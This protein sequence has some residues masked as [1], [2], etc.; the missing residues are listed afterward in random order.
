M[1]SYPSRAPIT[2]AATGLRTTVAVAGLIEAGDPGLP[3]PLSGRSAR[4]GTVIGA[5]GE[6]VIVGQVILA[7]DA[8]I[9]GWL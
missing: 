8:E 4:A 1:R 5:L 3:H 7:R 9:E 6:L 2:G